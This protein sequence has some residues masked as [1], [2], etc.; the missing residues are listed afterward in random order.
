MMLTATL[1]AAYIFDNVTERHSDAESDQALGESSFL[2]NGLDETFTMTGQV[3]IKHMIIK[4]D[5]EEIWAPEG[6]YFVQ[7]SYTVDGDE[8]YVRTNEQGMFVAEG[9]PHGSTVILM[10]VYL[11]WHIEGEYVVDD[12]FPYLTYYFDSKNLD[13]LIQTEFKNVT[14]DITVDTIYM[15]ELMWNGYGP[16]PCL[17][18]DG[19]LAGNVP[20][21]EPIGPQRYTGS[22][23]T[24]PVV[25][26]LD[27]IKLISG[28]DFIVTYEN[29]VNVGTATVTVTFTGLLEGKIII[30]DFDINPITSDG[31]GLSG[32]IIAT[33]VLIP[34]ILGGIVAFW[35]RP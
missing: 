28:V 21:M 31:G 26:T 7:I 29:N 2:S 5:Y 1:L 19:S 9:I 33:M 18:D 14:G 22:P 10:K 15:G 27:D 25:V 11:C 13:E 16:S 23:I 3:L 4:T 8:T 35:L 30:M 6:L 12:R 17:C 20:K 24:P 34:L 32:E